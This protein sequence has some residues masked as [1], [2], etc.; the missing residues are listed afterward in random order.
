M[1]TKKLFLLK[2]PI[3]ATSYYHKIF[4]NNNY[5]IILYY[6]PAKNS[7]YTSI[8]TTENTPRT[9]SAAALFEHCF[10]PS[11][12]PGAIIIM[13]KFHM[14]RLFRNSEL[15]RVIIWCDVGAVAYYT[16]SIA[17]F[18]EYF[19]DGYSTCVVYI[20]HGIYIIISSHRIYFGLSGAWPIR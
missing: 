2:H 13:Y 6:V 18:F 16:Q 14:E 17:L 15:F 19:F 4:Y 7:I 10:S 12:N 11:L 3:Y 1:C 20:S 8:T 5:K 9:C